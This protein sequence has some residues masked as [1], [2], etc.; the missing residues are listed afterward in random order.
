MGQ[1][2]KKLH[3]A[4][5]V[6]NDEFYTRYEDIEK[7]VRLYSDKFK[8]GV[9]Y[10]NCDN[11][12]KSEFYRFF[13]DNFTALGLKKLIAS[14]YDSS[15]VVTAWSRTN[16]STAFFRTFNGKMEMDT[17]L[18]GSGDFGS[19]ECRELLK[20]AT[21]VC[22]NPPFS[23]FGKFIGLLLKERKDF[24]IL[25]GVN[26]ASY[27]EC[28]SCVLEGKILI[29]RPKAMFF[30]TPDGEKK[31]IP[32][33]WYTTFKRKRDCFVPTASIKD[34]KYPR[35]VNYDAIFVERSSD[36]PCDY[37]GVMA[38]PI[39]FLSKID[40]SVWNL[41]G[42]TDNP[43]S[44]GKPVGEDFIRLYYSQGNTGDYNP[45]MSTL[46]F[47]DN[48]GRARFPYKHILIQRKTAL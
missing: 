23:L 13:K 38:V 6:R 26:G 40:Y 12:D 4:K 42:I 47:I 22:T 16:K 37:E 7:E 32:V 34:R 17:K 48:E 33:F 18:K 31:S 27:K 29:D 8:G 14:F 24:L 19:K 20:E 44:G 5:A 46:G 41:L 28:R 30:I 43:P 36:I 25:G 15:G 10:C 45:S 1:N 21:I 11:P 3:R 35:F 9:V 39:T 2:Y